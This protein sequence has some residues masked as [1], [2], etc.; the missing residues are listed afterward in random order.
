MPS[1]VPEVAIRAASRVV[2]PVPHPMSST[3]SVGRDRGEIE[4]GVVVPSMAASYR[5]AL[6]AQ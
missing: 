6:A 5:S 4:E 1:A 3:A 2:W